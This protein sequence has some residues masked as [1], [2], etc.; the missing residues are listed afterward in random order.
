MDLIEVLRID[1]FLNY[2]VE[3]E[4]HGFV[5]HGRGS[6]APVIYSCEPTCPT[7]LLSAMHLVKSLNLRLYIHIRNKRSSKDRS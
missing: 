1:T 7:Y 5:S 3:R 2:N 6:S 4:K